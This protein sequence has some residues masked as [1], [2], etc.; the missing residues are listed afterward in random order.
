MTAGGGETKTAMNH[1]AIK[2][3]AIILSF[4]KKK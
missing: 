3:K 1:A 2:E 4:K